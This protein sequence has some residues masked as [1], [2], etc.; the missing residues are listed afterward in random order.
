MEKTEGQYRKGESTFWR[1][2]W[3]PASAITLSRREMGVLG[4]GMRS[5]SLRSIW[6]S[7]LCLR[8]LA[9][10]GHGRSRVRKRAAARA[11]RA[12]RALSIPLDPLFS[13]A[14]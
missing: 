10:A 5:V 2:C 9:V 4:I 1:F 11:A 7:Q 12:A 3:V 14:D 8:H 6:V 13:K